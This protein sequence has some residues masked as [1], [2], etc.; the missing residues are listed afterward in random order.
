MTPK[1][2]SEK[3]GIAKN[4]VHEIIKSIRELSFVPKRVRKVLKALGWRIE[5]VKGDLK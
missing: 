1:Q 3:T 4:H 5:I 2:V